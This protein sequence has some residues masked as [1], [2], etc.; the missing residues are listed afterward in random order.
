[1]KKQTW[2]IMLFIF[3]LAMLAAACGPVGSSTVSEPETSGETGAT[4]VTLPNPFEE[5]ADLNTSSIKIV[6]YDTNGIEVGF[7]EDGR[8]YRGNR[9]APIILEEFSDYQCP[10]CARYVS[11]TL[12]SLLENQIANGD[13]MT[14]FYDFPLPIHAQ[15][16]TAAHATRCAGDQGAAAYWNMHDKIFAD[17]EA[18]S[19]NKADLVFIGYAEELGLDTTQFENCQTE[20]KYES[21]IQDDIDLARSRGVGSTP[22]FFVNDQMLVG[23]QPLSVFNEAIAI[24]SEGGALPTEEPREVE[25]VEI[26]GSPL[27]EPVPV[28]ISTEN[29]AFSLGDPDAPVTMVEFTDYQCPFCQR[30]SLETFPQVLTEMIENGR[31]HYIMK[32]FPLDSIHPDART[33]S[34]AAR[35]AGEQDAYLAMHDAI[36]LNQ[37]NWS[38]PDAAQVLA[39][40]AAELE[41]DVAAYNECM[42]DGRYDEAIQANLEEG[43][44]LGV[45]G[46]PAFFIGG[47]LFSGAL[48][49]EAFE[50][51]IALAETGELAAMFTP[52]G[53]GNP[54]AAV[55]IVEYTDFACPFCQRYAVETYPQIKENYVDTGLVRYIFKDLPLTSIH[56]RA[57]MAAFAARCAA[58][59]GALEDMR[60]ILF[61]RQDE[62]KTAQ[63]AEELLGFYNGYMEELGLDTAV[64]T[65]C[66]YTNKHQ[67]AIVADL[68]EAMSFGI[69]GTPAFF[70]NDTFI[71]GAQPYEEFER[72]IE[73][74]LGN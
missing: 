11:E 61:T 33:A 3:A 72:L 62:W 48:P 6:E 42:G 18:W 37:E 30:Y 63:D 28:E 52:F 67:T 25:P 8:P 56:P 58:D 27:I 68:E 74:M 36:F 73:E 23:A 57:A 19:N 32:D 29:A 55:T 54:D 7:T 50:S 17:V 1:M 9:N 44:S 40:L 5:A 66:L 22:S 60:Q 46:T 14:V 15:A 26:T 51:N 16:V 59:Q 45:T 20:G 21:H 70:I 12:P 39:G 64:F 31:V 69:Q 43:V 65:E 49:F 2:L 47:F 35:C 13:V 38:G 71:S 41:L 4:A 24:I 10:F 53:I 34:A